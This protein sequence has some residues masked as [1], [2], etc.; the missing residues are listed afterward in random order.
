MNHYQITRA[1]FIAL[2]TFTLTTGLVIFAYSQTL[3]ARADLF[4]PYTEYAA[5]VANPFEVPI[6]TSLLTSGV[7]LVACP[8]YVLMSNEQITPD[9][10]WPQFGLF[11]LPGEV[12]DT[13]DDQ[14]LYIPNSDHIGGY[15]TGAIDPACGV[16]PLGGPVY[17]PFFDGIANL[18]GGSFGPNF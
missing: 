18:D 14:S 1:L 12:L 11:Y 4:E 16:T 2:I 6:V 8:D 5:K 9:N 3:T 15:L 7:N 10:P 17:F 13:Y